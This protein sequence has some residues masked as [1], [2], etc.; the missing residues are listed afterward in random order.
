MKVYEAHNILSAMLGDKVNATTTSIPHGRRFVRE[1]R[2][3]YLYRAMTAIYREGTEQAKQLPDQQAALFLRKQ[4][5]LS[6]VGLN[7]SFQDGIDDTVDG[8]GTI[9][10]PTTET[11][12]MATTA[13]SLTKYFFSFTQENTS[14]DNTFEYIPMFIL[15]ANVR[16]QRQIYNVVMRSNAFD[17][18]NSNINRRPDLFAEYTYAYTDNSNKPIVTGILDLYDAKNLIT[19]T[20]AQLFIRFLRMPKNPADQDPDEELYIDMT[21]IDQMFKLAMFYGM[22]DSQEVEDWS[23][24][25]PTIL[26]LQNAN[27]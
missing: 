11:I 23:L 12:S 19:P 16:D 5:P 25:M 18:G 2:D 15:H 7:I 1:L 4:F 17:Y 27:H 8:R 21:H 22:V 20:D 10:P 26:G 3:G 24:I 6:I 9:L 13:Q 14:G